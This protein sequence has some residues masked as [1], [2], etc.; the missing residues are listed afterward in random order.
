MNH[1]IFALGIF[2]LIITTTDLIKTALSVNGAGF[3]SRRLAKTV[4]KVLLALNKHMGK[5]KIL[6]MSGALILMTIIINWLLLIWLSASLLF[7][8][9]SNSL[10]NV[11]TNTSTTIVNKIF[12][13]GYTLSTL[14]L[15]DIEPEGPFW[16]ILTAILSF[17]GLILISVAITYLIPVVSA[18]IEKR[19]ISVYITTIGCSVEEILVNYWN[20]SNFKELDK[21]FICLTD[22]IIRHGQNHKAYSVLHFFHTSD[23][24]EAFVLNIA[25]LD[26]VL[27]TLLHNIPEVSRPSTHALMGLRR[28]ISSYLVTLPGVFIK[29]SEEIPPI[30]RLN[31]LEEMNIPVIQNKE[32]ELAYTNLSCRRR[33]LLALIKDDGWE[34]DDIHAGEYD[35][36]I[37]MF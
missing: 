16:D 35:H 3:I 17:A 31:K 13:T 34:W 12:F 10:M 21:P 25:N 15:G 18:E 37:S 9:D 33:L 29:P 32:I 30:Q 24:K 5:R 6:E 27:T 11:E 8:S 23:K 20:G 26:E 14:G 36:E 22:M 19:K 4:W 1:Y 28:A 7:I 2:I